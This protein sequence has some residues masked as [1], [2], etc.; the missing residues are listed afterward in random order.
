M[1]MET[2][3]GL[4][5]AFRHVGH[6]H[7]QGWGEPLLHPEFFRM[8]A[9]AKAAGCRVGTTT[10][11]TLLDGDLSRRIV[12][13]GI[14]MVAV[15]L[16]GADGEGHDRLRRG[17]PFRRVM[18]GMAALARTRAVA[19]VSHPEIHVAY[20]LLASRMEDLERIPACLEGLGVQQVVISALD[21][22][23]G[24]T[25]AGEVI[26]PRDIG[27]G[28]VLQSR[29]EAVVAEGK[30]RGLSVH[31]HLGFPGERQPCCTENVQ[32]AL[33]VASD[34]T[35]TP[36]VYTSL[37][38]PGAFRW[39]HGERRPCVRLAMGNIHR[40]PLQDIWRTE[41]YRQ[42]RRSFSKGPL[43]AQ[44]QTCPKLHRA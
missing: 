11:G 2:F 3:M 23:A 1:S 26:A 31:Y 41:A 27:V 19:G 39:T 35:V 18:D 22:V 29:L 34:G 42:F 28:Q 12:D 9:Q 15:S 24:Q 38:I 33:V 10:N 17:A 37:E 5:P 40:E 21:Y 30:A 7:L 20:M 32:R 25:L 13:S 4:I 6:V 16:A 14:D 36:C 8:V 43:L 44:C